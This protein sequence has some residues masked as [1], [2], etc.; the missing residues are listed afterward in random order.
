MKIA[1]AVTDNE[2][3]QHFGHCENFKVFDVEGTD[4]VNSTVIPNPGH[5]PGFLPVFLSDKG[6]NVIVAGG[7]GGAAQ[8]LFNDNGIKVVVGTS[9]DPDI[10]IKGVIDGSIKSTGSVCQ[11]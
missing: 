1:I 11:H 6:V 8:N 7:M 4:I 2:I 10:V 5:R 3:S 9:G